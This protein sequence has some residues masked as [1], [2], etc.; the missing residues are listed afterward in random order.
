MTHKATRV[1]VSF[2]K[3]YSASFLFIAQ[4]FNCNNSK[5]LFSVAGNYAFVYFVL[6]NPIHISSI[7]VNV[8]FL[9]EERNQI[10]K[11]NAFYWIS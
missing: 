6:E 4:L 1:L 7:F 3:T 5:I 10:F 2:M 9:K 8:T 11:V